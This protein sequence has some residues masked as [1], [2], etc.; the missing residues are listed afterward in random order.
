V[1]GSHSINSFKRAL[2]PEAT[3]DIVEFIDRISDSISEHAEDV[4]KNVPDSLKISIAASTIKE[5]AYCTLL[6]N[7]MAKTA[8]AFL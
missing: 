3:Q 4:G 8:V 1:P 6:V 7:T 2:L 5:S